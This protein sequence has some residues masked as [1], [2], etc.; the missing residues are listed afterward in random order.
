MA[1]I[2][3]YIKKS[4]SIIQKLYYNIVPFEK[5]YGKEFSKWYR[6]ISKTKEWEYERVKEYQFLKLKSVIKE[7]YENVPYYRKI[8]LERDFNPNIQSPEDIKTLPILTK[9]IVR[10]NFK[11]LINTK[12]KGDLIEFKTSG[13]TGKK[14][15]FMGNDNLFKREAA[16]VLR[17]FNMHN[18]TMYNKPTVW[19]RR[20]A[21]TKNQPLYYKDHEL[22]RTYISPFDLSIK[23]IEKYIKIIDD[24]KSETIVTYP[25]LANFMAT[26]MAE[27]SLR[28]KFVKD[29][30]CASEMVQESWR[31]N[32]EKSIGIKMYAHYG[33]M[34]KVSF[35]CNTL[36]NP[37][38]YVESLE[39]GYTEIENQNIISTGFLNDVM[40]F[41]RY[42]PGDLAIQKPIT[43]EKALP[44]SVKDF[45]G[46]S[47][48]MIHTK[49]G[50]KLAGVNFY[51]MMYK[52]PGVEMFQITQKS[53]NEI[54]VDYIPSDKWGKDTE[55]CII[56]GMEDRVGKDIKLKINSVI[57]LERSSTGKF[58]TI[59]NEC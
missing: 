56:E 28:F 40:P 50:R 1:S 3:K 7:A 52:I 58:K 10:D 16:F 44:V 51:T 31:D 8:M 22:N 11:D 2:K 35:F 5:R 57:E 25:S 13:S 30:H 4:P 38:E 55:N 20:Y 18:S 23:T 14:F 42:M 33:M 32:I 26:L 45:I 19:I 21:P 34:E 17:A 43:Y 46:R 12:Y 36:D 47:T 37:R 41:I 6:F 53:I 29:I 48:D 54:I 39:Y 24:T 15:N 27:K 9:D 49:D 59:K